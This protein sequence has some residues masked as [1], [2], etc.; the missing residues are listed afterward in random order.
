MNKN[1]RK[2]K[3]NLA[4]NNGEGG[5]A[6]GMERSQ[7]TGTEEQGQPACGS[8]A[9]IAGREKRRR[10]WQQTFLLA[11]W[12]KT[13]AKKIRHIPKAN[14]AAIQENGEPDYIY[15]QSCSRN[16]NYIDENISDALTT[17][18]LNEVLQRF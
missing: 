12:S 8:Y 5:K 2:A 15:T 14:F 4:K 9:P 10:Q 16:H 18:E 1:K 3:N 17:N 6:A 7:Q 11:L 13:K